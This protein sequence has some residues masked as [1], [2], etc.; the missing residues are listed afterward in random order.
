MENKERERKGEMKGRKAEEGREK[1]REIGR[2]REKEMRERI[3]FR[4]DVP[5]PKKFDCDQIL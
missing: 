2:Q 4:E 3:V 5:F 1:E